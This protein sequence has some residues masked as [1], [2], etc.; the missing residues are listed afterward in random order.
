MPN[1][2]AE[3]ESLEDLSLR[4]KILLNYLLNRKGGRGVKLA[5]KRERLWEI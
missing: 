1:F 5:Q 3:G 2:D 4:R